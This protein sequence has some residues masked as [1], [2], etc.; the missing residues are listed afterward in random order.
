MATLLER[1]SILREMLESRTT[2]TPAGERVPL[3]SNIPELYAQALY[4]SVLIL[5]PAISVEIGMA[6]GVS[7]LAILSA[8]RDIGAGGKLISIDPNQ[9]TEWRSCGLAAVVRAGFADRH[10][11]IEEVDY[12]ALPRLLASKTAIDFAYIDGWHTFD[13]AL[14]D[15]WYIDKM[16]GVKGVVAF[17]DCEMPAVE[18]VIQF[19]LT[20]RKYVELNVGLPTMVQDGRRNEDRYFRKYELGEP[21]W[22]YYYAF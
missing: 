18:K 10:E 5:R 12:L 17:N 1:C 16:L 14:L 15:W 21:E 3:D 11:L 20:H 7:T 9:S 13:Y 8:L 22:N 6:N 4:Q 2:Q 19:V